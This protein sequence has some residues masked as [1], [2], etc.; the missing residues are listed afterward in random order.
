[1]ESSQPLTIQ[2]S[3]VTNADVGKVGGK[4]ASLGEMIQRLQ[5]AGIRVPDGFATTAEAYWQFLDRNDLR[6][7]I[8]EKLE[9]LNRDR[10]ALKDTGDAIRSLIRKARF[11]DDLTEAIRS[12]YQALAQSIGEDNPAVAVRSSATAEDLPEASFAGQ[13]ETFLNIRGEKALLDA[14]RR[15]MASLFSDRA[16]IYRR[17]HD[18]D[19]MDVALSVG[20]QRMVHA[21]TGGAGVMFSIDTETGFRNAVLIN[22]NWGLGETVVQGSVDPDEYMVFKPLLGNR[23][24]RPI[25]EKSIGRKEKKLVYSDSRRKP[26][27]T[28]KTSAAERSQPVLD[29][30]TILDLARWAVAIEDHYQRPM[31]MEWARDGT[32]NKMFI[33]QARPETVQSAREPGALKSYTLKDRGQRLVSGLSIGD[34]IA[35]GKVCKLGSASEISNFRDDGILVTGMTDPD[36]V[37]IMKRAAAIV[38]DHGGRTSHAAI[39][40]R[41]LGLPAIVGTGNATEAL[42][43]NQEVTVSC[44]EGD[45]GFVY[46]GIAEF[47]AHDVDLDNIPETRAAVMLNLANPAA[48]LRWWRLPAD[49]VGLAR[50]E[51][52]INNIIKIHPMALIHP[53]RVE[54]RK[55][56]KE[57]DRITAGWKDKTRYFIDTLAW[58]V[59]RIAA[60]QHPNPVIVR[61]SDFKT[62]E[63]AQL[64]GGAAFE[65]KEANPMLGWRG[66]SRYYSDEYREGFAMECRAIRK[67]REE[68]GLDNI[69]VMIPFCRTPEEADRVLEAMA[70][71]GLKRGE[72]GLQVYVMAE[73][74]SNITLADEFAQ[75]FDGFSIGSN[76]LTQLILGVDRDSEQLSNLFNDRHE[77]VKRTIA[78]LIESAHR[79]QRKVGLCG[80]APSDYPEFAHFLIKAGIDSISV[81]PDSFVAV[82]EQVAKAE[83]Q[84]SGE[85]QDR[86][87]RGNQSARSTRHS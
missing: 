25:I 36:W 39:V 83:A 17:N 59:A 61:M 65:P 45:E 32:T 33:V 44:A 69:I 9:Q 6:A 34:G 54:D 40:S 37:P 1:M 41:E 4:N 38:T 71:N 53:D 3:Q 74:P 55:A 35:A 67:A 24:V 42:N 43:N 56:R 11:P 68:I 46:E 82:K 14:C 70:E 76:D 86:V 7:R 16:I 81:N 79:H 85:P 72:H 60:S 15:C 75:R 52:I 30:E 80:Q 23:D 21:D 13:Q 63:Y 51:F 20:I 47:E 62:N 64:I 19:H 73:I 28:E 10:D 29:D 84:Q 78:S 49:G 58:G 77:A 31:D 57:I 12:D 87:H 18:I 8:S 2:L 26:T 50:M 5:E 27:R 66:A 22:A 48:A